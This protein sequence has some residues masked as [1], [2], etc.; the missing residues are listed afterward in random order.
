MCKRR[1]VYAHVCACEG[2]HICPQQCLTDGAAGSSVPVCNPR[3]DSRA[4]LCSSMVAGADIRDCRVISLDAF[5]G[6]RLA[7]RTDTFSGSNVLLMLL[8]EPVTMGEAAVGCEMNELLTRGDERKR[9][10]AA[11]R[12]M[13][14]CA[15]TRDDGGRA[16]CM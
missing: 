9:I 16:T 1:R 8:R 11:A 13:G 14:A 4:V 15:G 5:A 7:R 6:V 3:G 12:G 2:I 10:T